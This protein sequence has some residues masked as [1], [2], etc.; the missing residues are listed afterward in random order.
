MIY[1]AIDIELVGCLFEATN[2]KQ[3]T[4]QVF[5]FFRDNRSKQKMIDY[6]KSN[7]KD[8]AHIIMDAFLIAQNKYESFY[9]L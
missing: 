4:L 2:D 1:D 6:L 7:N 3:T 8:K 9:R 5:R